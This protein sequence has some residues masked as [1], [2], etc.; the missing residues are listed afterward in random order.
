MQVQILNVKHRSGVKEGKLWTLS[1]VHV[2]TDKDDIVELS[3]W[4]KIEVPVGS[5]C[6]LLFE[7]RYS[8]K[9]KQFFGVVVDLVPVL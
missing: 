4:K 7:G 1:S 6:E 9:T 2:K 5:R 3:V 8:Y